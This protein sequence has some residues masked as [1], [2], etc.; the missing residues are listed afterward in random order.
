[1]TRFGLAFTI[2]GAL[3]IGGCSTTWDPHAPRT[4]SVGEQGGEVQVKHGQRLRIQ[5]ANVGEH[6]WQREEPQTPAVIA[7]AP[8]EG[9]VWMFTPVRSGKETL[10]FTREQ[11][12]VT[13]EVTVP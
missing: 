4:I 6:A 5:L 13:Y 10:R 2:A 11:R 9:D 1:M 3:L 8:P 12:T 7:Q